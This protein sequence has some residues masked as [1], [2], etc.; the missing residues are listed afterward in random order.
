M[1]IIGFNFKKILALKSPDFK[2]SSINTNIEF[3]DVNK[4]K[5]ELFKEEEA[6]KVSFIFTVEY[7][8]AEDKE[9]KHGEISYEGDI[10]LSTNKEES[11]EILKSWKKKQLPDNIRLLLINFIIKR[12]S[13]RALSLEEDLGL[14]VHIP[15]PQVQKPQQAQ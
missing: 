15:F 5:L 11:K 3:K 6:L 13:I 12:C 2:R 14:P 1:Q 8:D 9:T 10:L 7:K 4:E